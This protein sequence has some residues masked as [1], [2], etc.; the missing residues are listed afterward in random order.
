MSYADVYVSI[1]V[2]LVHVMMDVHIY[3]YICD[4]WGG[5]DE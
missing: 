2:Y 1:Y 4:I 5:Y 3:V